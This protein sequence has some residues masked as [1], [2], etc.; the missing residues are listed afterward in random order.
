MDDLMTA[1]E[2]ALYLRLNYMTLCRLA[3]QRKVPAVKI[4]GEWRF[5]K[6]VL[7]SLFKGQSCP[8]PKLMLVVDDDARIRDVLTDIASAEE[9]GVVAVGAGAAALT[10]IARQSFDIVFLDLVL[11][12]MTGVDVL[13][14]IKRRSPE[15]IVVIVTGYGDDPIATEA[16][17]LGPMILLRKPFAIQD[18]RQVIRLAAP[19]EGGRREGRQVKA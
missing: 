13:K 3:R 10:E 18:V 7:D 15:T 11:P 1:S 17:S 4:G 9:C 12:D 2:A 14:E 5:K 19:I 16:L 6:D 8:E